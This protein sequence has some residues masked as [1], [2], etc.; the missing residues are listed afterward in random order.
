MTRYVRGT[1]VSPPP[2]GPEFQITGVLEISRYE[3]MCLQAYAESE[4]RALHANPPTDVLGTV[5]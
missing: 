2:F 4:G 5:E 1:F 3:K